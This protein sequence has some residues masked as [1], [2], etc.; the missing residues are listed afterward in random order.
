KRSRQDAIAPRSFHNPSQHGTYPCCV[1]ECTDTR[2]Q[3]IDCSCAFRCCSPTQSYMRND[4]EV[5]HASNL[6]L[7][8]IPTFDATHH[9]PGGT[10]HPQSARTWQINYAQS[11]DSQAQDRRRNNGSDQGLLPGHFHYCRSL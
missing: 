2:A 11:S 4:V 7:T 9:L 8:R 5:V 1:I 6:D 3:P 10:V